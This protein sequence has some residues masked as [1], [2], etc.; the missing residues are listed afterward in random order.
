[1]TKKIRI[2][3]VA[4]LIENGA[5][6]AI[7][8]NV[9]HRSP[10]ALL[11]ELVKHKKKGLKLIKTAGAYDVDFLVRGGCVASVDAGFISY[12]T[13]FGLAKYYRKA[14]EDGLV[15][16]NEH[17]CYT[18]MCALNAAKINSPF[19]PVYGLQISDLNAENDYFSSV[20]DPFTGQSVNVV[21]AI[22][23]DIALIHVHECDEMGNAY[24]E[25]PHYDDVLM[26]KA[27]KKVIL[28]AERIVSRAQMKM[29]FD[30]LALSGVLIDHVVHAPKGAYPCSCAKLYD[31]D[32]KRISAFLSLEDDAAFEKYLEEISKRYAGGRR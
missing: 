24:I 20:L 4:G 15:K 14:V 19:M 27:S 23:P 29:K 13:E 30:R 1:M 17:A 11:T 22:Q 16:A 18:V 2:D 6:V 9:L 12:E 31:I 26:A 28:S 7:G 3:Q 32:K 25:G 5:T 21:K 10:N 8:G